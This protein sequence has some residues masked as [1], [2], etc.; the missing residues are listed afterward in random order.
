[1]KIIITDDTRHKFMS[2]CTDSGIFYKTLKTHYQKGD[3]QVYVPL[4]FMSILCADIICFIVLND[5]EVILDAKK[6]YYKVKDSIG[7]HAWVHDYENHGK[8]GFTFKPSF[9][10]NFSSDSGLALAFIYADKLKS[11]GS[12]EYNAYVS[13][14]MLKRLFCIEFVYA[15]WEYKFSESKV[16]TDLSLHRHTL[17]SEQVINWLIDNKRIRKLGQIYEF[18]GEPIP[19]EIK[20]L[21][22]A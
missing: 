19:H 9:I 7:I 11:L 22:D 16:Y 5:I 12:M 3:K 14:S 17:Y 15:F 18:I 8:E 10:M 4:A 21:T 2:K 6:K 1:M 20:N 13:D